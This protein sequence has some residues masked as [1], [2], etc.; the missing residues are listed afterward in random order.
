MNIQI[1]SKKAKDLTKKEVDFMNNVRLKTYGK[2]SSV[3]FKKEDKKGEF[4]FVKENVK[5]MAFGMM[6]PVKIKFNGKYYSILG[7]G[8]GIAVKQSKGWG[9]ILNAARILELKRTG[10]TGVAFTGKHNLE[11]FRK[12]GYQIGKDGIRKFA[13]KNPK[14]GKLEYD[15]DGDLVYYEGNDEF[16]T[17]LLKSNKIAVTDTDF[18]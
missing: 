14:T 15:S 11:F 16:I 2:D 12:V 5:I 6:K 4:I 9:K 13:Y 10:K 17:K 18:W 1:I 7:I 3:D 8:R